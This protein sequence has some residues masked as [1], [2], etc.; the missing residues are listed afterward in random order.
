M[1]LSS[2]FW[3]D[4]NQ[5]RGHPFMTSTRTGITKKGLKCGRMWMVKGVGVGVG[6]YIECVDFRKKTNKL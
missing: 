4:E 3:L 5:E 2:P 1:K 6:G